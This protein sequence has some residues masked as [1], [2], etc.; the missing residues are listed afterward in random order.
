MVPNTPKSPPPGVCPTSSLRSFGR[1]QRVEHVLLF[2]GDTP[3]FACV[4]D[5]V[6]E[7]K[8]PERP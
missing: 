3:E 1:T 5:N 2:P 6:A 4:M 8:S 7:E